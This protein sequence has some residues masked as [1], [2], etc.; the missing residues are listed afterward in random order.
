MKTSHTVFFVIILA[1]FFTSGGVS[2]GENPV[3]VLEYFDDPW[4]IIIYDFTGNAVEDIDY[5]TKL[6]IG[7]GIQTCNSCAELRLEPNGSIMKLNPDTFIKFKELQGVSGTRQN[8]IA[9]VTGKMR[10]VAARVQGDNYSI[11]TP[12]M[13]LGVR[14]TDFVIEI[15]ENRTASVAVN[16]GIVDLF[17]PCT[18]SSMEIVKG[19]LASAKALTMT[20]MEDEAGKVGDMVNEFSFH[21]LDPELV[22][23][24]DFDDYYNEFEYF[25]DMDRQAYLDYFADD[26]FFDDYREYMERF[27]DYYSQEMEDFHRILEE[28]EQAVRESIQEAEDAYKNEMDAFQEYLKK[29]RQ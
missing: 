5:G 7:Y 20:I 29:S 28:E 27:K 10:V 22:P 26:D 15:G 2:A 19:E 9:H 24:F 8:S 21:T 6:L 12:S 17:N 23:K 1:A 4:E 13:A 18:G 25:R 14:G 11:Q 3:A 16:E